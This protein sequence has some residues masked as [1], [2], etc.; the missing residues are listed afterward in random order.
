MLTIRNAV[1]VAPMIERYRV[2][3]EGLPPSVDDALPG[4]FARYNVDA[5]DGGSFYYEVT[6]PTAIVFGTGYRLYSVGAD[7]IDNGGREHDDLDSRFRAYIDSPLGRGLDFVFV[8]E[9]TP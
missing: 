2:L 1:L 7:G 5:T 6:D 8:G 4:R 3:G 9:P